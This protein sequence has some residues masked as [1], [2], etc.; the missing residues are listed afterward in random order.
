MQGRK[1]DPQG[2]YT[3]RFVPELSR[4]PDRYLF[5]PW[6]APADVLRNAGIRPG[7][8]Y[9]EPLAD[10]AASRRRALDAWAIIR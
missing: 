10:L 7:E 1:F 2:I 8:T 6:E 4:L 9:P 3:R 5:S